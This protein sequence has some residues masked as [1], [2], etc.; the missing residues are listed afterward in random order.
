MC[1]PIQSAVPPPQ[2]PLLLYYITNRRQFPGTPPE[3]QER[4]LEKIGECAASGV[5]YIQ[6]REK[7]LTTRELERLAGR[8]RSAIPANSPTRLLINSRLDVALA[9]GAHGVHL[10]SNWLPASE[11]RAILMRAG[12]SRPIIG[13]STHSAAEVA[14]AE[15]HGADFVVFG[16][17][18]EKNGA[19]NRNGLEQLA[20]LSRRMMPVF[21]LGG[22]TL[23]NAE[24]SLAAGASGIAGIRMFQMANVADVVKTL[25]QLQHVR[26]S[27]A[28]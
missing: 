22:I 2:R 18:F 4:L 3:Q 13:V 23:Q 16:P 26:T 25:R 8:A 12:Q 10:P 6:L 20:A 15:A 5:D 17:A 9:C 7:D 11:A 14:A 24:Q 28:R 19:A 27:A 21:A 1:N